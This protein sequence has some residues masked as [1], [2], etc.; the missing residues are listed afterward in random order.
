MK[1]SNFIIPLDACFTDQDDFILKNFP[2]GQY[3]KMLVAIKGKDRV[4]E[5]QIFLDCEDV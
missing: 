5:R 4:E 2:K 3:F 1:V